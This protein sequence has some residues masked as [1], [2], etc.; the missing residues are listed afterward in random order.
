MDGGGKSPESAFRRAFTI[1]L[2]SLG[3]RR[4]LPRTRV[5]NLR[6]I[7]AEMAVGDHIEAD[8]ERGGRDLSGLGGLNCFILV[9]P[10]AITA[11][12]LCA[13]AWQIGSTRWSKM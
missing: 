10:L 11:Q 6:R 3:A 7:D 13:E 1:A 4:N 8:P 2:K 5:S 12:A 9:L